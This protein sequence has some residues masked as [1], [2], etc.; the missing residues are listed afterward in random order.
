PVV[1]AGQLDHHPRPA[2]PLRRHHRAHREAGGRDPSRHQG[3]GRDRRVRGHP[4]P[5]EERLLHPR[6]AERAPLEGRREGGPGDREGAG[7][8]DGGHRAHGGQAQAAAR[9]DGLLHRDGHL[10]ARRRRAG[11]GRDDPRP[12]SVDARPRPAISPQRAPVTMDLPMT[13]WLS[14]LLL[15]AATSALA[16]TGCGRP[17]DVKTA[18]GLV[19]LDD[20]EPEYAYRAIAPERVV[21][22]VRVV[23]TKGRGDLEF[24]TRATTLRMHELDGYAL[25]GTA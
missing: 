23:D 8:R 10:R 17:F 22:A 24:W 14:P 20:Q 5:P 4:G 6:P 18:P 1:A 11:S 15:L 21:M 12:L 3:A 2:R 7:T 16:L 19:E 13:R 9:P 25:L